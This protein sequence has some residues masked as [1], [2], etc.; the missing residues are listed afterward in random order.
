MRPGG[1]GSWLYSLF[2]LLAWQGVCFASLYGWG[3][4]PVFA[5][6][7]ASFLIMWMMIRLTMDVPDVLFFRQKREFL[8]TKFVPSLSSYFV[9]MVMFMIMVA[10]GLFSVWWPEATAGHP[11]GFVYEIFCAVIAC[12]AVPFHRPLKGL[13]ASA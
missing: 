11:I 1:F 7:V 9:R 10:L 8:D 2:M 4:S 12:V 13:L 6:L 3:Y 5:G